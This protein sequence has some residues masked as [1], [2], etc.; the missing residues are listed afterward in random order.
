MLDFLGE[1]DAADRIRAGVRRPLR[2]PARTTDVGDAIAAARW[3][4]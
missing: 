1:A 3:E 2:S 4:H